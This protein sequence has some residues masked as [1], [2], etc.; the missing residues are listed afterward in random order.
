MWGVIAWLPFWQ[1]HDLFAE[2]SNM[3]KL[4]QWL[5]LEGVFHRCFMK[6]CICPWN[7]CWI[8]PGL[9][10]SAAADCPKLTYVGLFACQSWKMVLKSICV[11]HIYHPE[12][13]IEMIIYTKKFSLC[14]SMWLI[15][16]LTMLKSS[17][18]LPFDDY[19]YFLNTRPVSWKKSEKVKK[20]HTDE[21]GFREQPP[22]RHPRSLNPD[23]S[24]NPDSFGSRKSPFQKSEASK[25]QPASKYQF[26][27]YRLICSCNKMDHVTI[28]KWTAGMSVIV[29]PFC[30]KLLVPLE[31][32]GI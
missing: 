5:Y 2:K 16:Y 28:G 3:K 27:K 24:L 10:V 13:H 9:Y 12:R 17:L 4:S 7:R 32:C 19:Y 20:W 6:W 18:I 8:G 1:I 26:S 25:S 29:F 14:F 21:S 31:R 23:W 30:M 11:S 22:C 15:C